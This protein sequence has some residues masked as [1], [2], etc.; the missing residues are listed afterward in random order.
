MRDY[1]PLRD[2]M[3]PFYESNASIPQSL[4]GIIASFRCFV[5]SCF[6][7]HVVL[8]IIK[9]SQQQAKQNIPSS[10]WDIIPSWDLIYNP[11][12][13]RC[14]KHLLTMKAFIAECAECIQTWILHVLLNEN[15]FIQPAMSYSSSY[16]F[17]IWIMMKWWAIAHHFMNSSFSSTASI[18]IALG[19][20]EIILHAAFMNASF[21]SCICAANI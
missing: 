19:I 16:S 20:I 2:Y 8:F 7:H 10:S 17:Y 5:K 3:L 11:F 9:S 1:I 13:W 4:S 15:N 12:L 18:I 6:A 14:C 21:A